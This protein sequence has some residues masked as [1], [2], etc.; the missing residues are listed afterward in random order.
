MAGQQNR[1]HA[2]AIHLSGADDAR[3]LTDVLSEY[4][5]ANG[6]ELCAGVYMTPIASSDR[7]H[8]VRWLANG[9]PVPLADVHETTTVTRRSTCGQ[10]LDN[11]RICRQSS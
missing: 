8:V 11:S 9:Q 7:T 6:W 4:P 5:R 1:E 10:A 3:G 2:A